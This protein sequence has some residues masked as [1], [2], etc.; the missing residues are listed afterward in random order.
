MPINPDEPTGCLLTVILS[1]VVWT[2]CILVG[3]AIAAALGG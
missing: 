1:L 2:L 3:C